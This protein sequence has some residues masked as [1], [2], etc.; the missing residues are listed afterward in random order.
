MYAIMTTVTGASWFGVEQI[1]F[2]IF[3]SNVPQRILLMHKQAKYCIS[4]HGSLKSIL[5]W[6]N[7]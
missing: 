4:N 3:E 6:P 2:C 5:L 7:I 1:H